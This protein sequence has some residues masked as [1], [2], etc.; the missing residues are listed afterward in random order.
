MLLLLLLWPL[1]LLKGAYDGCDGCRFGEYRAPLAGDEG[2]GGSGDRDRSRLWSWS[3][4]STV[5]GGTLR[6]K[7][8]SCNDL[9]ES[10]FI[11]FPDSSEFDVGF[12]LAA[13]ETE[14]DVA[15]FLLF[16]ED[17]VLLSSCVVFVVV[18][19]VLCSVD[20][21]FDFVEC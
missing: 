16:V 13:L 10:S 19:I 8:T 9:R 17:D 1:L 5:V 4:S 11:V 15:C 18:I 2:R 20:C 7:M 14:A 6:T 12:F 21:E 3:T